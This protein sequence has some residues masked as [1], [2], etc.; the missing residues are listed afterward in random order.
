MCSRSKGLFRILWPLLLGGGLLGAALWLLHGR[1]AAVAPPLPE[2]SAPAH[3]SGLLAEGPGPATGAVAPGAEPMPERAV[4]GTARSPFMFLPPF[5]TSSSALP[6]HA[7]LRPHGQRMDAPD[8]PGQ[9]GSAA[10]LALAE[11]PA[12]PQLL[13]PP[14]VADLDV[15]ISVDSNRVW[16]LVDPGATV[17]V[18][19]DGVQMGA[20][21]A[22]DVGFFWTTL[23]DGDGNRPGLSGGAMVRVYAEGELL[24]SATL[25]NVDATLDHVNDLIDGQVDGSGLPISVTVYNAE[26]LP[27]SYSMTVGTDGVGQFS[28]NFGALWDF[29]PWDEPVVAYT[30]GGAEVYQRVSLE[31]GLM[32]RPWPHNWAYGPAAPGTA[33]TATVY[34]SDGLT[35]KGSLLTVSGGFY[36]A[37]FGEELGVDLLVSDIVVVEME[38]GTVMSRTIDP[39]VFSIDAAN[40]RIVGQGLPF[41]EVLGTFDWLLTPQ[42][43]QTF[44]AATTADASGAFT[45]EFGG[46]VDVMPGDIASL[47]VADD[48]GDVLNPRAFAPAV[49][50]HQTWNEVWGCGVAPFGLGEGW[51]VTLTVYS[52]AAADTSVHPGA[53]WDAYGNYYFNESEDGLPDLAPGDIVTV[54]TEGGWFGVVQV[55][56]M[57]V[58]YDLPADEFSG[59]VV[60]PT[61]RVELHGR[62]EWSGDYFYPVAGSF[63]MFVLANSPF[64]ATPP[65]FDV[66]YNLSYEIG[67]RTANDYLE[68]VSGET[69]GVFV[70]PTE[71][72]VLANLQ[73]PNVPFT[74]TL[75]DGGGSVKAELTAVSQEPI[76]FSGWMH[77]WD[78]GQRVE[79]GD[80]VQV[81]AANGFSQTVEIPHVTIWPDRDA[82]LVRGEAPAN[83]RLM[84]E[85]DGEGKGF[86]PSNADGQY[87]FAVGQLQRAEGDGNLQWGED[88]HIVTVDDENHAIVR[89]DFGWPGI[90]AH[91]QMDDANDVHGWNAFPG[92]TILIT[93]AHP[94]SGVI[95]TGA[96]TSGGCDGCG[97]TDYSLSFPPG[98]IVPDNQVWVDFGDGFVNDMTVAAVT[99]QADPDTDVV[100]ITAPS[101]LRLYLTVD[102]P[103]GWWASWDHGLDITVGASGVVT[104]DLSLYGYDLLLGAV[105]D[106]YADTPNATSTHY[107]F[108]LPAPEVGIWKWNTPGHARPGGVINYGVWYQNNGTGVATDTLI[109]DTLPLSTTYA[110]DNSGFTPDIGADGVITWQVGDLQP[111]EGHLFVVT[112]DV[113]VS[114]PEGEGA[115]EENCIAISTTC[116][117]YTSPSPRDS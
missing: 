61:E 77:F 110:G 90:N 56:T 64:T 88:V 84:A 26:S 8:W 54:E 108:W 85:V 46:L 113:D 49:V 112:L 78:T 29:A 34:L 86:V 115:L 33:V 58:Q 44:Q 69:G 104:F 62:Y 63:D 71:N 17:T 2:A 93:V 96:T 36:Y 66:D 103:N 45:I 116:L 57:T 100:T 51:P 117:L 75:Y 1:D 47:M 74:Y 98:T 14:L 102:H 109:V 59:T 12:G 55:Q 3:L 67:H 92:S 50:V 24:A 23:Y 30:S 38:D 70:W 107:T 32:V 25:R 53:L 40:D 41:D 76:G 10:R 95:A 72:V 28:A 82:D 101:G 16:G 31:P 11:L 73:A 35:V 22:D 97:S 89:F 106:A 52:A 65:G 91:Y 79:P 4:Q 37:G 68:R 39:L 87:V 94:V 83:T 21:R 15:A 6:S 105:L 19:V 27:T 7:S 114:V 42:G 5:P 20:A 60:T 13:A 99:G 111:G 81:W 43:W 80:R 48:E 18:T 9:T